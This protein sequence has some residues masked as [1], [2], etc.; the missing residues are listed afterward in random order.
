VIS[1]RV[2]TKYLVVFFKSIFFQIVSRETILH[3]LKFPGFILN[4]DRNLKT[5][6]FIQTKERTTGRSSE[7]LNAL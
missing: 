1:L 2:A 6:F 4:M 5:L 7:R 3:Q